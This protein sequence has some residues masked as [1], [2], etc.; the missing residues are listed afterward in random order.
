MTLRIEV[1][2]VKTKNEA[3]YNWLKG[4]TYAFISSVGTV[5]V[6]AVQGGMNLKSAVA[7]GVVVGILAGTKNYMKHKYDVD[8]DLTYLKK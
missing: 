8:I 1:Y 2:N 7:T 3:I 4:L 5:V 6:Q